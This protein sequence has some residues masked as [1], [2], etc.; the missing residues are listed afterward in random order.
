MAWKRSTVEVPAGWHA[1]G[2]TQPCPAS[3]NV[4]L[5]YEA[6]LIVL[7]AFVLVPDTVAAHPLV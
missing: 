7:G 6:G 1:S 5:R 4:P 3:P 2:W